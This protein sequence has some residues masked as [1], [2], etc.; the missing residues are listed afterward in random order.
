MIL[1]FHNGLAIYTQVPFVARCIL[2]SYNQYRGTI[3]SRN[4]EFSKEEN[5]DKGK[6][7]QTPLV[8]AHSEAIITGRALFF[9]V[10]A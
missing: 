7:F 2:M 4:D 6:V 3:L 10:F 5:S 9:K 8:T 1:L